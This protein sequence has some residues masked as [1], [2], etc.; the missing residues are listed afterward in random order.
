MGIDTYIAVAFWTGIIGVICRGLTLGFS[1]Y[2]RVTKTSVGSD[3]LMLL[4]Q[5]FFLAW[6]CHLKYYA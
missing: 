1:E 2:P 3:T 6:V 5:V 4:V